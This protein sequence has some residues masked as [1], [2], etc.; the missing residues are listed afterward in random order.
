MVKKFL[1]VPLTIK[2]PGKIGGFFTKDWFPL[3][4]IILAIV[5]SGIGL[6]IWFLTKPK[7]PKCKEPETLCNNK[8]CTEN[9]HCCQDQCLDKNKWSCPDGK[10]CLYIN[11]TND[12][13]KC[14]SDEN[15]VPGENSC[16]NCGSGSCKPLFTKPPTK[17]PAHSKSYLDTATV[18]PIEFDYGTCLFPKENSDGFFE[19]MAPVLCSNAPDCDVTPVISKSTNKFVC[20]PK[21]LVL[22]NWCCDGDYITCPQNV[23]DEQVQGQ[24][25]CCLPN[26]SCCYNK[27]NGE[28]ACCGPQQQCVQGVC[29][30]I[31]NIDC[32]IFNNSG[33]KSLKPSCCPSGKPNTGNPSGCLNCCQQDQVCIVE[34]DGHPASSP[35]GSTETT[36][37]ITPKCDLE[38]ILFTPDDTLEIFGGGGGPESL[39]IQALQCGGVGSWTSDPTGDCAMTHIDR[40]GMTNRPKLYKICK[41]KNIPT[42]LTGNNDNDDYRL[43]EKA[44]LS[45]I[46][47]ECNGENCVDSTF[48]QNKIQWETKAD[49]LGISSV[50]DEFNQ[51][52]DHMHLPDEG[53]NKFTGELGVS[54]TGKPD[55]TQLCLN[56]PPTTVVNYNAK[57][58]TFSETHDKYGSKNNQ[59]PIM[60]DSGFEPS[61]GPCKTSN[62][63]C[64]SNGSTNTEDLWKCGTPQPKSDRQEQICSTSNW[65]F[66]SRTPGTPQFTGYMC[67]SDDDNTF[68]SYGKS[69][70][71]S[72]ANSINCYNGFLLDFSNGLIKTK[73]GKLDQ[74]WYL[75]NPDPTSFNPNPQG[76]QLTGKKVY[77]YNNLYSPIKQGVPISETV[78]QELLGG[79]ANVFIK[80]DPTWKSEKQVLKAAQISPF[81]PAEAWWCYQRNTIW[82]ASNP[83]TG[84][85]F[86]RSLL[87]CNPT[88]TE[89]T[90]NQI[91][92][93]WG[94]SAGPVATTKGCPSQ[95]FSHKPLP[96][97][98]WYTSGKP[99]SPPDDAINECGIGDGAV[100]GSDGSDCQYA[101]KDQWCTT[102]VKYDDQ[103]GTLDCLD[104]CAKV[105]GKGGQ[106]QRSEGIPFGPQ[107][108]S[109][110]NQSGTHSNAEISAI[111]SFGGTGTRGRMVESQ[112]STSCLPICADGGTPPCIV[113]HD[114]GYCACMPHCGGTNAASPEDDKN[115]AKNLQKNLQMNGQF[116]GISAK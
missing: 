28:S 5:G 53:I 16:H 97:G 44:Q 52:I 82:D 78:S 14:C 58:K 61:V 71:G 9:Q 4:V 114:G 15:S 21:D 42:E 51:M 47:G 19:S 74:P 88:K 37:C 84:P 76:M 73:F 2:K 102:C 31:C 72:K 81:Q 80:W 1:R 105:V 30:D 93:G 32:N 43:T 63:T 86:D 3:N 17:A 96:R 77:I 46:S 101:E 108:A 8:C 18:T 22:H 70:G 34:P 6:L 33:C 62:T 110:N 27:K 87:R 20:C 55:L 57:W 111:D 29:K 26:E 64:I 45:A 49:K 7:P 83:L 94:D 25:R 10:K 112:S 109:N 66:L 35:G 95:V 36:Q 69:M 60:S 107:W 59:T 23:P 12:N 48:D 116:F 115:C 11:T 90:P 40:E 85:S 67:E 13:H 68:C 92:D 91:I 89:L 99:G 79:K 39:N 113:I 56:K 100:K 41:N 75:T 24:R 50:N 65:E 103:K 98:M 54:S 106:L 104:V 38:S